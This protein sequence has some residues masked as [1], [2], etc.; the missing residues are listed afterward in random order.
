MI[1]LTIL[2]WSL[3][4]TG[5]SNSNR[6]MLWAIVVRSY[7]GCKTILFTETGVSVPSN[8]SRLKSP[9]DSP[10]NYKPL[11]ILAI[12]GPM[13]KNS[14]YYTLVLCLHICIFFFLRLHIQYGQGQFLHCD[15]GRSMNDFKFTAQCG[16]L[17]Y[18]EKCLAYLSLISKN[19]LHT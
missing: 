11:N 3:S 7:P 19:D 9:K 5:F 17:Y 8:L 15:D 13:R 6:A 2:I 12:K 18:L 4:L 16:C 10:N 14:K 1:S